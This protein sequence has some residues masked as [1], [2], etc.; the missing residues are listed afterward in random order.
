MSALL[1]LCLSCWCQNIKFQSAKPVWTQWWGKRI[2]TVKYTVYQ[3]LQVVLTE[4]LTIVGMCAQ[5]SSL[6]GKPHEIVLHESIWS[7]FEVSCT[8]KA[9]QS[10]RCKHCIAILMHVNGCVLSCKK[11]P[12]SPLMIF[13]FI[14]NSC[15]LSFI[16]IKLLLCSQCWNYQLQHWPLTLTWCQFIWK[17]KWCIPSAASWQLP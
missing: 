4:K 13:I 17:L 7:S 16:T 14:C 8:C 9:G 1:F 3:R 2:R 11:C 6:R 5:A 15:F 10:S 12:V